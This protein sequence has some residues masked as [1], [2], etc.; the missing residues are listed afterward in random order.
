LLYT[1]FSCHMRNYAWGVVAVVYVLPTIIGHTI[2]AR[3][4]FETAQDLAKY[5]GRGELVT[6][7]MAHT[8]SMEGEYYPLFYA[9]DYPGL[10]TL[11]RDCDLSSIR[12]QIYAPSVSLRWGPLGLGID[13]KPEHLVSYE[14]FYNR[15]WKVDLYRLH[16]SRSTEMHSL[17]NTTSRHPAG[18]PRGRD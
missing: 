11:N 15:K 4:L 9:P 17:S 12:Y 6:G 10:S 8:L 5:V 16:T 1:R 13:P 14:L 18:L 3:T 2:S 7:P